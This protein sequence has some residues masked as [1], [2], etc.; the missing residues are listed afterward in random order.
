MTYKKGKKLRDCLYLEDRLRQF[1]ERYARPREPWP[2]LEKAL[3][4]LGRRRMILEAELENERS[5]STV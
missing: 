4:E 5:D 1:V 2:E 3:K